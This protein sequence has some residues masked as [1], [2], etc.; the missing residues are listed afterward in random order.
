L[1]GEADE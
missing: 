1:S